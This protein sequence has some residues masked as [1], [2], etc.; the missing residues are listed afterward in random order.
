[1]KRAG[2]KNGANFSSSILLAGSLLSP[3]RKSQA[4][5]EKNEG[6]LVVE[7][8]PRLFDKWNE[9]NRKIKK[10]M[11]KKKHAQRVPQMKFGKLFTK[12]KNS[13]KKFLHGKFKQQQ[14]KN[15]RNLRT[16]TKIVV[17]FVKRIKSRTSY[18]LSRKYTETVLL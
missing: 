15:S 3:T 5:P 4:I 14:Q 11:A 10:K 16:P 18:I 17:G 2:E 13:L 6:L 8:L 9:Y 12:R 1:M 7:S